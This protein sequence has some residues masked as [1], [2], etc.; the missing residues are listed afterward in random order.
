MIGLIYILC[1]YA[2]YVIYCLICLNVIYAALRFPLKIKTLGFTLLASLISLVIWIEL[3]K[4]FIQNSI[5]EAEGAEQKIVWDWVSEIQPIGISDKF[6]WWA[7]TC[8]KI[9]TNSLVIILSL[10]IVIVWSLTTQYIQ[11]MF[12]IPSI[13]FSLPKGTWKMIMLA[14]LFCIALFTIGWLALPLV[15]LWLVKQLFKLS[16]IGWS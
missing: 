13:K 16:L 12:N 11:K 2:G 14:I 5:P 1:T 8:T 4:V 9:A 6:H 7:E 15:L 10:V 3:P